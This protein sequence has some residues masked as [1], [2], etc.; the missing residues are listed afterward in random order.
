MK[1]KVVC[2]IIMKCNVAILILCLKLNLLFL[3]IKKYCESSYLLFLPD[4][5][6]YVKHLHKNKTYI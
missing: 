6:K 1:S 2:G 3:S 5:T 4:L